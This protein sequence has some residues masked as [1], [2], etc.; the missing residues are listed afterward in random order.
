MNGVAAKLKKGAAAFAA[1]G[2][3]GAGNPL[4]V[5]ML[6]FN[7]VCWPT[8]MTTCQFFQGARSF[9]LGDARPGS[10]RAGAVRPGGRVGRWPPGVALASHDGHVHVQHVPVRQV[11]QGPLRHHARVQHEQVSATVAG[12]VS[13][14]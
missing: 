10:L 8:K 12:G 5:R 4:E 14:M 7:Q 6:R 11:A 9:G 1:A 2:G 3:G 13:G